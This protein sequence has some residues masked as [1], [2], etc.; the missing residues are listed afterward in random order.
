MTFSGSSFA[1]GWLPRAAR[2]RGAKLISAIIV[3]R[4]PREEAARYRNAR[5]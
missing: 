1:P 2:M 5:V 3:A 4:A